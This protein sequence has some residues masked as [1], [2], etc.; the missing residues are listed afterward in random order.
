MIFSA[1]RFNL[2][3]DLMAR[4]S[5]DGRKCGAAICRTFP[6]HI[7][8]KLAMR[9]F[10][11]TALGRAQITNARTTLQHQSDNFYIEA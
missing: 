7:S 2:L 11:A 10:M 1:I 5:L 9:M 8:A 4:P 6:A 3:P